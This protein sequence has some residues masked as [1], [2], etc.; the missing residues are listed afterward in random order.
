MNRMSIVILWALALLVLQ[1]ALAA[2]PRQQPTAREQARTVTIFHQPVVMLQATFGQTTPEER[3]LRTRSALRAFTE[4]DIRQPLRVVPVIRYG[5]PGRLFLMN[6]KPVLLL[7]Q[8]DLDEGDDLTLDQAAQRVLARME[9]QR[10]SLQEQFN[11]RY[12]FIS[13]GKA[14]AGALLLALFY[15]GAFRAWRRVR[16]FF[17]LRILEK[18]SAIPQHWRRYLGNIEVRLYAV[19]VILLGMLACY[20]WL[21]WAFSLFPWTRV[22]SESLGDWSLGV[23]RHLSLSIVASLPGL[24]IVVLIFLLTW[25]IIRLVKVVLDQVAAGRIQIPGIHPETVSATRRLISVVIW[26]FALS[27]AYPFLP[28]ANSLAFKGISVFFGLI[29]TLGS[30]GVMTHAMSGLVLIYSRALRKGDWIRLA[31]NEGQVSEIGVLAT[32]ILTRE[33]YIV[34]APNAVV[35]SGKIINLSAESAD[36]GVNLTT[37]VTIGYDTPWRQV[38]ALL[39]LAA[40]RTPGIDQQIAPVVRKLGLLDWYTSY[41]LQ[42]R[43]LPTTKLPDGRNALHSSIIDVFNEFGVQIMSPN[44]VMQPK[45]AVVVPQ[46]AW[47]AAPA[48][49]P[50]K[51]EK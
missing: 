33:N 19:L 31:D 48:V 8:A 23:I 43:L 5:Q 38:H 36:G 9:A 42:V 22:W 49:A 16:R 21:S 14:L 28:G 17:L 11:N 15:Y 35:V 47:Y 41:E 40:R 10:T 34:T 2:E 27:A 4:D 50:Q 13:A 32:K 29:L 25:L 20:L 37:S 39:E 7:S 51:P 46:E 18:R 26:L 12:L 30:T 6:G 3:V 44:F 1:P 45:A 24:M